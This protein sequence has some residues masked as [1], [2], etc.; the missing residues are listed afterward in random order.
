MDHPPPPPLEHCNRFSHPQGGVM[1]HPAGP[2]FDEVLVGGYLRRRAPGEFRHNLRQG[3]RPERCEIT[4]WDR[5]LIRAI[6][7]HLISEG[8][9][10]AGL[11]IIGNT[12][13]EIN[14]LNAGGMHLVQ[15]TSGQDLIPSLVSSLE[16]RV[17]RHRREMPAA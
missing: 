3:G 7:P 5:D 8:V 12:L 16:G 15:E 10:L 17:E 2:S 4:Q 11:D 13:L 14:T 6:S 9:W 1:M